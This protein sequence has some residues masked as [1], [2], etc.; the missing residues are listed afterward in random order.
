[1]NYRHAFH[2]GNFA[3]LAKHAAVGLVLD[4][5]LADGAAL[6]VV[7]THAGAGLYDLTG[8]MAR[9]S[10]EAE[11]GVLRLMADPDAPAAFD[12]LK[13]AVRR[14][15]PKDPIAIYPGSP[16]LIASRLRPGDSYVGAELHEEDFALLQKT[17]APFG[18]VAR[19]AQT[20]GY[21]LAS[22]AADQAG[23]LFVLVDPPFERA[24]DY[25]R[26]A[27]LAGILLRR[28]PGAVMAI[29]TPLK[30]L[31]TFDAFV[32]GLEAAVNAPVLVAELRLKPLDNPLR[33]NG[34]AM[35]FINAPKPLAADFQPVLDWLAAR[36]G[37][38]GARA[39]VWGTGG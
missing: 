18:A 25:E 9:K 1:L 22:S 32:S 36:L 8:T 11:A 16:R 2:A 35:V 28:K 34:C 12:A 6:R 38:P 33:L 4:R 31:E 5:L 10:G 7:D 29:W 24:D 23:R 13:A 21:A 26:T 37:E 3:D 30:D 20:D 19:A 17:L 27:Q 15:N 14:L 39:R